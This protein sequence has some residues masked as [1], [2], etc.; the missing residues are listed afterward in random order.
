MSDSN[1]PVHQIRV[2]NIK[3]A[4]WKND[5]GSHS[6]TTER[7]YTD[8]DGAWHSSA[9]Y[10][11]DDIPKLIKALADAYDWIFEKG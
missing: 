11:R 10:G 9:S 7:V 2:G 4:I 8:D 3:A 5:S 6:V 1:P